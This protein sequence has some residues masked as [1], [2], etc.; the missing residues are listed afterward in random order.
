MNAAQPPA[1]IN[2]IVG[3]DEFLAERQR[4]AIVAAARRAA[5]NPELPVEM[6]KASDLSAPEI[7]ELLSPSLFADDRIIVIWGVEDVAKEIVEA[8]EA[9]IKDPMPGVVM[10]LQH[11]GKGRNKKL[12]QSWPKLGARVHSAAELKGRELAGFVDS[13]FRQRKVRV[14][15]DVTQLMVDVVGSDLRELS[16]AVSQLVADTNGDVTV[17]AVKKYYSG[18]AEVSGFDVAELA[19]NGRVNEAVAT[20]RRALQL[21]VSPVLLASALSGMV[22]DIAK[23]A[24]NRRIDSRRNAAEFGMPPWK[25]DKTIRLA[26]A[27][28][29]AAVAQGVQIVAQLDAGVKGQAAD[30]EYAVEHA[31]R[32]IAQLVARR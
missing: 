18:K 9:S 22:A 20:V 27:W 3:A 31:V 17:A 5:G 2:L 13:E 4:L 14:S 11:T 23:V 29:P 28:S 26:R 24:E 32:S 7:L 25:L 8:I 21:G 15:P 30:V 6:H 1:P 16:S 12:V 10:I 19:V